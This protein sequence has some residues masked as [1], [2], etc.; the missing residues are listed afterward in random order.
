MFPKKNY[1]ALFGRFKFSNVAG[2]YQKSTLITSSHRHVLKKIL[3]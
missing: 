1:F 3:F 2:E